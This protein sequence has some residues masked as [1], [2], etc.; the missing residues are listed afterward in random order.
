MEHFLRM[1]IECDQDTGATTLPGFVHDLA[2]NELVSQMHAI[3]ISN[4]HDDRALRRKVFSKTNNF[5]E[6]N[7]FFIGHPR[8]AGSYP[9]ISISRPRTP[10]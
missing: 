1:R 4:G 3:E 5:H 7:R 9:A 10:S 6:Q 8:I 2:D